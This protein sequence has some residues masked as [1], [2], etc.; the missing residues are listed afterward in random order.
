MTA[1]KNYV[2]LDNGNANLVGGKISL[3]SALLHFVI[4]Y[5]HCLL[6]TTKQQSIYEGLILPKDAHLEE[7]HQLITPVVLSSITNFA[8]G[9]LRF[10]HVQHFHHFSESTP[11]NIIP[12]FYILEFLFSHYFSS[13]PLS[14]NP[15]KSCSGVAQD[16]STVILW[17]VL[18]ILASPNSN[19]DYQMENQL[20]R[21]SL[22]EFL[23][24]NLLYYYQEDRW[25]SQYLGKC[26]FMSILG[27]LISISA[28][29]QQFY[30]CEINFHESEHNEDENTSE[31]T[32]TY[33]DNYRIKQILF[34]WF[35]SLT[36]NQRKEI[37]NS[38]LPLNSVLKKNTD[39]EIRVQFDQH[40][41]Q[42]VLSLLLI[43][44]S[45][46]QSVNP[47][48]SE[49]ISY[50]CIFELLLFLY[51]QSLTA[52]SVENQI[53][54]TILKSM[55]LI[56]EKLR[57]QNFFK[58]ELIVLSITEKLIHCM[59]TLFLSQKLQT[60]EIQAVQPLLLKFLSFRISFFFHGIKLNGKQRSA[61]QNMD[62]H[63]YQY[64]NFNTLIKDI[65]ILTNQLSHSQLE[66]LASF[67]LS[68]AQT[69]GSEQKETQLAMKG[70]WYQI[71]LLSFWYDSRINKSVDQ[72]NDFEL[73][74]ESLRN[75]CSSLFMKNGENH[76]L[77]TTTEIISEETSLEKVKENNLLSLISFCFTSFFQ[78]SNPPKGNYFKIFLA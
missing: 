75:Y 20:V 17:N 40:Q 68:P 72:Q 24:E 39:S 19:S 76:N 58:C 60:L 15:D 31:E 25:K 14:N 47:E 45:I 74:A 78:L 36:M 26:L 77:F 46:G 21:S 30:R 9:S 7:F 13:L 62:N 53:L 49:L 23:E 22:I 56:F 37:L 73:D 28:N 48:S 67:F 66:C 2:S 5:H 65:L 38:V 4:V 6:E 51:F 52:N 69:Y 33:E 12:R 50:E 71:L 64:I 63:D 54:Q 70:D 43:N 27:D 32:R 55:A 18:P 41:R 10:F 11:R 59:E 8:G 57:A 34:I 42:I 1:L 44:S 3:T 35:Q 29:K 16:F 61:N